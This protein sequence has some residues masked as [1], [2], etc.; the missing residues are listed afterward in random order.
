M[1]DRR[2]VGDSLRQVLVGE[3][4]KELW[5]SNFPERGGRRWGGKRGNCEVKFCVNEK[6]DTGSKPRKRK[7]DRERWR[8]VFP[9]SVVG[10]DVGENYE[11]QSKRNFGIYENLKR[12]TS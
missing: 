5:V 6:A 11:A 1:A 10:K 12:K 3:S 8:H 4:H 9:P 7:I 2:D